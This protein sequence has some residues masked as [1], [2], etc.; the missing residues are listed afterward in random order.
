MNKA[1]AS[2]IV[3]ALIVLALVAVQIEMGHCSTSRR[4]ETGASCEGVSR[5]D[6]F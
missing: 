4:S 2:L 3:L 5:I 6:G 1:V